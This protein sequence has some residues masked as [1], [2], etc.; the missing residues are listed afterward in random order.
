MNV[1]AL[2][3]T[4]GC[5]TVVIVVSTLAHAQSMENVP[6]EVNRTLQADFYRHYRN[7]SSLVCA[8]GDTST[9][10]VADRE[11]INNQEL[12]RG[13]NIILTPWP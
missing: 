5:V 6:V 4:S 1:Q 7:N 9:Y 10:M 13:N 8:E 11:C 2:L 12:L 3:I